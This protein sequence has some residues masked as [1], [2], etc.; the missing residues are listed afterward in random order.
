MRPFD[1]EVVVKSM[2]EEGGW[3]LIGDSLTRS[4]YT[5]KPSLL[6]LA[7]LCFILS[8]KSALEANRRRR[9]RALPTVP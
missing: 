4:V 5:L 6:I 8:T 3:S 1:P 7:S 2:I 9:I